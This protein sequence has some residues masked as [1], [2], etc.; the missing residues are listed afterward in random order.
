VRPRHAAPLLLAA[1]AACGPGIVAVHDGNADGVQITYGDDVHAT[2]ALAR[3]H[4]AQ[5]ERVPRFE[6][7]QNHLAYYA[8][9][10]R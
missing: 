4:C 7:A 3:R 10:T 9:E 8:C 6:G 5:Y 2:E 1:L